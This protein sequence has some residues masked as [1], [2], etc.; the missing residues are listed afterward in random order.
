MLIRFLKKN[1][2][3]FLLSILIWFAVISTWNYLDKHY[4]IQERFLNRLSQEFVLTTALGLVSTVLG[5]LYAYYK[6]RQN[7]ALREIQINRE[8]LHNNNVTAIEMARKLEDMIDAQTFELRRLDDF[9]VDLSN[10]NLILSHQKV[11]IDEAIKEIKKQL[12]LLENEQIRQKETQS[13]ND[14]FTWFTEIFI[15]DIKERQKLKTQL[16][17]LIVNLVERADKTTVDDD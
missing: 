10:L 17:Q 16:E 12:V 7:A 1:Y 3:F 6:E 5:G 11:D 4:H 13:H 15:Q 8:I 9:K 2:R 14:R